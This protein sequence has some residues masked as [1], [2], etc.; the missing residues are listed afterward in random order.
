M[1]RWLLIFS[2]LLTCRLVPGVCAGNIELI[3]VNAAISPATA[4]Y[5]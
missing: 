4:S 3:T 5:I 2:V 1:R